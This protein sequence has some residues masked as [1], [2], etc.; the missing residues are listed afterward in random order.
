MRE[1]AN[2]WI[3]AR[4]FAGC[5]EVV[6]SALYIFASSFVCLVTSRAWAT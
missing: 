3:G 4:E 5:A 6:L 1:I 2:E